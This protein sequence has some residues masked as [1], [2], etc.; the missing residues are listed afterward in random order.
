MFANDMEI[1]G[2]RSSRAGIIAKEPP[3]TKRMKQLHWT[4]SASI[5]FLTGVVSFRRAQDPIV[6]SWTDAPNP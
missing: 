5:S 4:Y 2:F 1:E 6:Y 3:I